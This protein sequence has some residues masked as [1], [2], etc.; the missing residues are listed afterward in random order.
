M[1]RKK[2]TK[3]QLIQSLQDFYKNAGKQPSSEDARRGKLLADLK[4]YRS[5]FGSWN[6]AIKEAGFQPYKTP[7]PKKEV[8]CAY[9][10]KHFYKHIS[11]IEQTEN[12]F[13]SQ[14]C[15]A[16][17]NNQKYP[18]RKKEGKCEKCDTPTPS[19][20]K[21]CKSCKKEQ[22]EIKKKEQKEKSKKQHIKNVSDWRRRTKRK[23]IQ[24]K[25]G[26]CFICGYS[27]CVRGLD[28]HHLNPEEKEFLIS[29]K[30]IKSW[31]R[32]KKELDKCIL[33]C[34]R[35]HAEIHSNLIIMSK[36]RIFYPVRQEEG[37]NL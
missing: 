14:S 6:N 5:Y 18:K 4:T 16:K 32:L 1:A 31:D 10:G 23:A 25:G 20:Q 7:R 15:A 2:Y 3:T 17:Y 22:K 19:S 24:Y 28:F 13:C 11:Q 26:E 27:K 29:H 34:C 9:C 21:L 33:V 35:C 12:N 30:N 37:S 36:N 8:V